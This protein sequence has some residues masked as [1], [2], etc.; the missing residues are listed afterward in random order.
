MHCVRI[1]VVYWLER[2][3]HCPAQDYLL[4]TVWYGAGVC[5]QLRVNRRQSAY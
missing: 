1:T 2:D 3:F 5:A 4:L